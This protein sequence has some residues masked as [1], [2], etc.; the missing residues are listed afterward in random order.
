[1]HTPVK[2]L[3]NDLSRHYLSSSITKVR[4][5]DL[6]WADECHQCGGL[7]QDQPYRGLHPRRFA[8]YSHFSPRLRHNSLFYLL[9]GGGINS[10]PRALHPTKSAIKNSASTHSHGSLSPLLCSRCRHYGHY[11]EELWSNVSELTGLEWQNYSTNKKRF[12]LGWKWV[13]CSHHLMSWMYSKIVK[14]LDGVYPM[15]KKMV[16][17]LTAVFIALAPFYR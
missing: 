6:S 9:V 2:W 3:I 16:L 12:N 7:P 11:G 17:C 4:H 15:L 8:R 5:N 14:T 1:M 10:L 13:N